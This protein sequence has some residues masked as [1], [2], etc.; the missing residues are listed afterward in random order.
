MAG[1]FQVVTED[2]EFG[3]QLLHAQLGI[4]DR[5]HDTDGPT[6]SRMRVHTM[7]LGGKRIRLNFRR[8][9]R[10]DHSKCQC[11]ICRCRNDTVH[12]WFDSCGCRI[13]TNRCCIDSCRGQLPFCAECVHQTW[14]IRFAQARS[15]AVHSQPCPFSWTSYS[16]PRHAER[17]SHSK[18]GRRPI[19]LKRNSGFGPFFFA[20]GPNK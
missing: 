18:T 2:C 16:F 5:E 12:G 3:I 13:G 14:R 20:L 4:L 8:F 10:T 9:C 15:F 17:K 11:G 7:P 6:L 19:F 1:R